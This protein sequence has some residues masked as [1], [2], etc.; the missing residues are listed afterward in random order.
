[1]TD[2]GYYER[3]PTVGFE[4]TEKTPPVS[5]CSG[6]PECPIR[7][8]KTQRGMKKIDL[9][10]APGMCMKVKEIFRWGSIAPGMSLKQNNL[11]VFR[12]SGGDIHESICTYLKKRT[13]G[14]RILCQNEAISGR[15][16]FTKVATKCRSDA[17][18]FRVRS[19]H[20]HRGR[21]V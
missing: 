15:F 14:E 21:R 3:V 7:Q 11:F 17:A 9:A 4:M 18:V 19:R 10:I 2:A 5:I 16:L 8:S 1:M 20:S 6:P 13:N 12:A